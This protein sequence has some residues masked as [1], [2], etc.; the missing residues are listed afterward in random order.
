MRRKSR[1][2]L[3]CGT[4]TLLALTPAV[5][6]Q[7]PTPEDEALDAMRSLA[8][9]EGRDQERIRDWVDLQIREI[10]DSRE[11]ES[12][13]FSA[14][15]SAFTAQRT[16]R[17]S[18]PAF[19]GA[20]AT[21]TGAAAAELLPKADLKPW[22]STSLVRV[23]LDLERPEV[24]DGL[25]AGMA[26][27]AP[28]TRVLAAKG[29]AHH[30]P[31]ISQDKVQT[32]RV[33]AALQAAGRSETN[34]LALKSIYQALA[35]RNQLDTVFDVYLELLDRRAAARRGGAVTC[36]GAD[37]VAYEFL[38]EVAPA[39]G[40]SAERQQEVARRVAVLLRCDGQRYTEEQLSFVEIDHL[41]RSLWV[42]EDLLEALTRQAGGIRKQIETDGHNDSAAVLRAVYAWVGNPENQQKG[43]LNQAPWD[44]P[45]GAP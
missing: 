18:T 34:P 9:V 24:V 14:F 16:D 36:D 39:G 3:V 40:L 2:R 32:Q 38:L 42:A 22:V 35:Y 4:F 28:A 17:R 44:V 25:T 13:R 23:L 1:L 29:L 6:G 27:K 43:R 31:Q 20:L 41:E 5:W 11:D 21:Q 45:V 7:A 26:A 10:A 12:T 19:V 15:R 30:L 8:T 37:V 33:V